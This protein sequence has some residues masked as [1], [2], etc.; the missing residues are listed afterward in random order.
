MACPLPGVG[1][2][3]LLLL[4]IMIPMVY[5]ASTPSPSFPLSS[6]FVT[7]S[8][9]SFS[10]VS[11]TQSGSDVRSS[12]A[13][14]GFVAFS[15]G[16]PTLGHSM[17]GEAK[18]IKTA[19]CK[20]K[21]SRLTVEGNSGLR[22]L[23]AESA[24]SATE[25]DVLAEVK[26]RAEKARFTSRATKLLGKPVLS[27]WKEGVHFVNADKDCK[28]NFMEMVVVRGKYARVQM[29]PNEDGMFAVETMNGE[30]GSSGVRRLGPTIIGRIVD[31]SYLDDAFNY[32]EIS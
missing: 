6:S 12:T 10:S 23:R 15:H 32:Y 22:K 13:T 24:M 3:L 16:L 4:P 17:W 31:M 27:D 9:S 18:C 19:S 28:F 5:S 8:S 20:V 7:V 11:N 26:I 25:P 1:F 14:M 2:A 21:A 29:G 30:M